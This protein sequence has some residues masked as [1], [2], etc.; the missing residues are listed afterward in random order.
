MQF[1]F[2]SREIGIMS[3]DAAVKEKLVRNSLKGQISKNDFC[4]N[5]NG[6]LCSPADFSIVNDSTASTI[7]LQELRAHGQI[8]SQ[9]ASMSR[10]NSWWQST[11]GTECPSHHRNEKLPEALWFIRLSRG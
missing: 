9:C 6:L 11:I 4:E 2:E 10:R 3:A 5:F 1:A 7:A 8:A